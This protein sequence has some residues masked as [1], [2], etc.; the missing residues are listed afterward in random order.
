M[1]A[2]KKEKKEIVNAVENLIDQNRVLSFSDAVFAFAATLLVLKIDLPDIGRQQL[3]AGLPVELMGLWPTYFANIISFLIIGYY[4][5][6]HHTI[7]SLIKKY[8]WG[9]VWVNILFL[10]TLSFLPF[11]VDLFGDFPS[12]PQV[13]VF[14]SASLAVVGLFLVAIWLYAM[15]KKLTPFSFE[16][17]KGQY[18]TMRMLVAPVIFLLSIPLAY[19][20]P[21]IAQFSWAF[22]ILGV[23]LVNHKFK[24]RSVSEIEKMSL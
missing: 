1:P 9:I 8:D 3:E 16:S 24:S 14:Y 13:V 17:Q 12:V 4:W 22:V 10:T 7:F 23:L 20:D 15:F 6:H 2:A 18:Y 19:I 11:P 21:Q 5:L